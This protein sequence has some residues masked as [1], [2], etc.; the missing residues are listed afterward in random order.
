MVPS[1]GIDVGILAIWP[2]KDF[3]GRRVC[4]ATANFRVGQHVRISKSKMIFTKSAE[5]NFRTEILGIVK[6]IDRRP[7]KFYELEDLNGTPTDG[8]L[9]QEELT[10]VCTTSRTTYTIDSILDMRVISVI[11]EYLVRV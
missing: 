11:P 9:Y 6:V 7:R 1:R 2:L 5:H 4:V 8:Q 3:N 10:P